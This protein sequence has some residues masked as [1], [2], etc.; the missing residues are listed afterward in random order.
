MIQ[1][2]TRLSGGTCET[3]WRSA[4]AGFRFPPDVIVPTVRWYLRFGLS[5]RD[6]EELLAESHKQ[7][8]ATNKGEGPDRMVRAFGGSGGRI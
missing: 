5:S 6:I 3:C 4:S 2:S 1:P 8:R 7:T